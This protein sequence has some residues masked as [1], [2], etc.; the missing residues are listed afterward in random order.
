M[1]GRREVIVVTHDAN[2]VANGDVDLVIQLEA[3]AQCSRVE[4][5]GAIEEP[6]V[7]EAIVRIV[8]GG[9]GAFALKRRKY[10]FLSVDDGLARGTEPN[11]I[12]GESFYGI[13]TG[14][15]K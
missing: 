12:G 2:V 6:D 10:G 13:Q 4:C 5:M 3:T 1:R 7:R 9:K 8:D 11:R 14:V 15:W